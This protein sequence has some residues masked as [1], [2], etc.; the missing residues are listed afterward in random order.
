MC[1]KNTGVAPNIN[2]LYYSAFRWKEYDESMLASLG[3]VLEKIESGN[4]IDVV[5]V[6]GPIYYRNKGEKTAA[7]QKI[8]EVVEKIEKYGCVVI[9]GYRFLDNF[10]CC[11]VIAEEDFSYYDVDF[12]SWA[13]EEDMM[14]PAF[15]CK[16][17][18]IAEWQ[19][20]NQYVYQGTN[21]DSWPISQCVG[22]FALCRQVNKKITYEEK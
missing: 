10:T 21:C 20:T 18:V 19:T 6:S 5:G 16:G 9:D 7:Q 11:G 22:L 17:Q 2:L 4:Q 13:S 14:K 12:V 15:I 3:D 8:N 1:G